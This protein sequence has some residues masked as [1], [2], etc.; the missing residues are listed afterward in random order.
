MLTDCVFVYVIVTSLQSRGKRASGKSKVN[1]NAES[2]DTW[3]ETVNKKRELKELQYEVDLIL[4]KRLNG[5]PS[6]GRK[7][8]IEYL[9]RWQ[10]YGQEE[11]T[12]EPL[13]G[14][15]YSQ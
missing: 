10:G 6:G 15:S 13:S 3:A 5:A 8:G 2:K 1:Y 11:D 7:R 4:D 14:K 9:V 12:W